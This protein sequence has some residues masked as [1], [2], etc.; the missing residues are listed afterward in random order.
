MPVMAGKVRALKACASSST[1]AS[2]GGTCSAA[3]FS[4]S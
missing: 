4:A 2:G 1:R 3:R